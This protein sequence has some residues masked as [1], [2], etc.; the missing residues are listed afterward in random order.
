MGFLWNVTRGVVRSVVRPLG[1]DIVR[2]SVEDNHIDAIRTAAGSRA[3]RMVFDVGANVGQTALEFHHHFPQA[4]IHSFEPFEEAC[5]DLEQQTRGNANIV[6]HQVALGSADGVVTLYL[7]Q[8]SV[9]NSLLPNA[10]QLA[11]YSPEGWT[12]PLGRTEVPIRRLDSFCQETGIDHIDVLKIDTQGYE[13]RV[14]EGAGTMLAPDTIGA[15]YLEVLFVPMYQDQ[16]NFHDVYSLLAG[17]GYKLY[18]LFEKV[19]DRQ[20]GLRWANALFVP[21][22]T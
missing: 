8:A 11:G 20:R 17:R 16:S 14:L 18:D 10:D 9:T 5:G 2:Y 4:T 19:Y 22:T 1:L 7:N 21:P 6:V 3:I 12:A 13:A 15:V